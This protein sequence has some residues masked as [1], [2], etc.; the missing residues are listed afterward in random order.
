MGLSLSPLPDSPLFSA[1]DERLDVA[2]DTIDRPEA[3]AIAYGGARRPA[4]PQIV[5]VDG[6]HE[7]SI[8]SRWP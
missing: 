4:D 2:A 1:S 3:G 8:G 6:L 7:E 5:P